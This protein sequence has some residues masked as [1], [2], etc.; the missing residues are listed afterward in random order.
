MNPNIFVAAGLLFIIAGCGQD[1]L[2]LLPGDDGKT[3]SGAVAVLSDKG[4][5]RAVIDQAYADA[6][7]GS[8]NVEQ[9]IV[10][11]AT[12]QKKYGTLLESLP[13]PPKSY[14]IY[15]KP[16][17]ANLTAESVSKVDTLFA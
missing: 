4:E 17:T 5:T 8:G 15:F 14:L 11:A 12:V 9:N 2:L 10:D 6:V 16:G 3:S 7:I 1:H 13:L